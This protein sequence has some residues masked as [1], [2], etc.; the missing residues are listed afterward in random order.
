MCA[1]KN[2]VPAGLTGAAVVAAARELREGPLL[3]AALCHIA[4][5]ARVSGRGG[6]DSVSAHKLIGHSPCILLLTMEYVPG[7]CL[8]YAQDLVMFL[9]ACDPKI[10][11]VK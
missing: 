7:S 10:S 4:G 2:A 11:P 8:L 9:I 1:M 6:D 5:T 3:A